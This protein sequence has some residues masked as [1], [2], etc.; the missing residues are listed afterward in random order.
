MAAYRFSESVRLAPYYADQLGAPVRPDDEGN[1][2][3]R[4]ELFQAANGQPRVFQM[5]MTP[6]SIAYTE[7]GDFEKLSDEDKEGAGRVLYSPF[8]QVYERL[9]NTKLNTPDGEYSAVEKLGE[10]KK[11]SSKKG[12]SAEANRGSTAPAQN[13]Q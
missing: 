6:G 1:L 5:P 9:A 3:D 11:R 2:P 13:N 7:A 8:P 4:N 12:S 10:D